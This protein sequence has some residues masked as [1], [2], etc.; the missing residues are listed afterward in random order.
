MAGTRLILP[1]AALVLRAG[2]AAGLPF[3]RVAPGTTHVVFYRV[4]GDRQ[5]L[6]V[7]RLPGRRL[8]ALEVDRREAGEA[9]E[10]GEAASEVVHRLPLSRLEGRIQFLPLERLPVP[11]AQLLRL[12]R[13]PRGMFD[14]VR[15]E[16]PGALADHWLG[17]GPEL[18]AKP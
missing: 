17:L 2:P 15:L 10:A 7:Y 9:D 12:V 16:A 14:G 18:Q 5:F 11:R 4:E 3:D 13:S 1:L 8:V 6:F